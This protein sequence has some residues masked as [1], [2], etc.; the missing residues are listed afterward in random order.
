[1]AVPVVLC[2]QG[3]CN[4][5]I[6]SVFR[7]VL[8][9]NPLSVLLQVVVEGARYNKWSHISIALIVIGVM[10]CTEGEVNFHLAGVAFNIA[11]TV[12]R[13]VKS[14][15]QG[16]LLTEQKLDSVTPTCA[17]HGRKCRLEGEEAFVVSR[18]ETR[19]PQSQ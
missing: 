6:L 7:I 2:V 11:A 13:A 14:I 19:L 10:F 4:L 18:T 9:R 16:K 17:T 5:V 12:L 15:L 3:C 1:M 8:V